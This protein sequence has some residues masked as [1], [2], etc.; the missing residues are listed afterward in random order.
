M[1]ANLSSLPFDYDFSTPSQS[2]RNN[3]LKGKKLMTAVRTKNNT[4][5]HMA[6]S[7]SDGA[8]PSRAWF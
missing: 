2:N 7:F 3:Q 4:N 1:G 6:L 5:Q 8:W